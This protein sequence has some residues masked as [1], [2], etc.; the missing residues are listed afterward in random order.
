MATNITDN[1]STITRKQKREKS[2]CVVISSKISHEK[3]WT[4]PRK[5][6]FKRETE[7]HLI[8]V[9]NN[10]IRTNYVKAR[11]DKTQHNNVAI[12]RKRSVIL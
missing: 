3:T 12:E 11:I 6:N 5:R 9:Q 1:S 10:A 8:T 2:K 4:W 7:Y